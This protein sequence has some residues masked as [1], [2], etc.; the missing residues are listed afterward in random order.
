[1]A[2]IIV[3]VILAAVVIMGILFYAGG[4]REVRTNDAQIDGHIHPVNARVEGTILWVNPAVENT[5]FVSAG[6]EVA[7][8]D[9]NDYKPAVDRLEGDEQSM[10]A[11]L[12]SAR[13]NVP[14]SRASAE[15]K[16]ESARAAVVDAEAELASARAAKVSS[17]AAVAQMS[18]TYRRAENDRVRYEALV[19]TH[20]ISRSEYDQKLPMPARPKL[21]SRPRRGKRMQQTS[22]SSCL[23]RRLWKEKVIFLR[24]RRPLRSLRVQK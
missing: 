18:A 13:L 20:E 16:L 14:I 12:A 7:H 24:L 11:Q 8:L 22:A 3:L 15:S 6:T 2:L 10:Q 5:R 4:P 1:M 17:E 23:R 9:P 19:G 21:S